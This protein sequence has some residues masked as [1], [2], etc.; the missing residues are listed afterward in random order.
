MIWCL[1]R[2][3]QTSTTTRIAT[4]RLCLRRHARVETKHPLQQGLR[5]PII[6][7]IIPCTIVETKHPLQQGLRPIKLASSTIVLKFSRN[8]TSTTTRIA[9]DFLF[10]DDFFF[11]QVETKHPLQQGL[12]QEILFNFLHDIGCVETK[13]PLQQGLRHNQTQCALS[14]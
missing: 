12:R 5:Q 7:I 10:E 4:L 1:F 3:N 11:Y 6:V 13:H 2:R 8:Q 14:P 9:T